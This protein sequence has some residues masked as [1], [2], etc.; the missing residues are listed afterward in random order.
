MERRNVTP[1]PPVKPLLPKKKK[2]GNETKC[3]ERCDAK[4]RVRIKN[5]YIIEC[6]IR[7]TGITFTIY[8]QYQKNGD[9]N[10]LEVFMSR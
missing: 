1:H 6:A 10:N 7:V 9:P 5:T 8:N 2:T 4:P 3:F